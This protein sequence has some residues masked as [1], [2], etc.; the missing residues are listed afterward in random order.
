MTLCVLL[1][2]YY[3]VFYQEKVLAFVQLC[4]ARIRSLLY[5]G[6][7]EA[8]SP[9]SSPSSD[10]PSINDSGLLLKLR[11][12]NA[13]LY[14]SMSCGWTA[15]QMEVFSPATKA[16]IKEEVYVDCAVQPSACGKV[17]HFP[18]WEIGGEIM[19]PGMVS[20]E[21][22]GAQCDA[23]LVEMA[24]QNNPPAALTESTPSND[25]KDASLMGTPPSLR[26]HTDVPSPK[27]E[28][29]ADDDPAT[30]A[31]DSGN[32]EPPRVPAPLAPPSP[33]SGPD[34]SPSTVPSSTVPRIDEESSGS[35]A[36]I[37]PSNTEDARPKRK[38]R[39]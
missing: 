28:E 27:Y 31:T 15:Q 17:T 23:L 32:A 35:A 7:E 26:N 21:V 30:P 18:T 11:A 29:V 37:V 14:G 33:T 38:K 10:A 39:R 5:G 9:A 20:I 16:V 3:L 22:L 36:E 25:E 2:C 19:P 4:A 12:L 13:K 6:G 1:G 8:S 34:S 24:K